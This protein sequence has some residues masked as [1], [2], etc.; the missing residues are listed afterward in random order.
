MFTR[1]S[2]AYGFGLDFG[3]LRKKFLQSRLSQDVNGGMVLFFIPLGNKGIASSTL[4]HT[5]KKSRKKWIR[6]LKK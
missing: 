3:S 2:V 5:M 6:E 1:S 4:N